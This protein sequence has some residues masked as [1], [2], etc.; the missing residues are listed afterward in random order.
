MIDSSRQKLFLTSYEEKRKLSRF[1][2]EWLQKGETDDVLVEKQPQNEN[3]IFNNY[4]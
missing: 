1:L 4:L 3:R 2:S